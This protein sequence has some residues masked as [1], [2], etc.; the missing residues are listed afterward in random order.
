MP[1]YESSPRKLLLGENNSIDYTITI[2]DEGDWPTGDLCDDQVLFET[3]NDEMEA[4]AYAATILPLIRYTNIGTCDY[5]L[6]LNSYSVEELGKRKFRVVATYTDAKPNFTINYCKLSFTV[7]GETEHIQAGLAHIGSY[8]CDPEGG[9]PSSAV[10]GELFGGLINVNGTEVEGIDIP[11]PG[12]N[13]TITSCINPNNVTAEYLQMLYYMAPSMNSNPVLGAFAPG[14]LLFRGASGQGD[15][16]QLFCIDF[17]FGAKPNWLDG[18]PGCGPNAC[19]MGLQKLGWDL[20]WIFTQPVAITSGPASC[21]VHA[22]LP[23]SVHVE[24]IFCAKDFNALNL[25]CN[26]IVLS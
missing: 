26:N 7:S 18:P 11:A 6:H 5:A 4:K 1:F 19:L 24:R 13:F 12:L 17:D 20:Y 3:D 15:Q 8:I 21:R 23:H 16:S 9:D 22:A 10:C 25:A 2:W 14:E